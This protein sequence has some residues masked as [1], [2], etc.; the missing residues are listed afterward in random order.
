MYFFIDFPQ[1]SYYSQNVLYCQKCQILW[2]LI[3][4]TP[5]GNRPAMLLIIMLIISHLQG[6]LQY[7]GSDWDGCQVVLIR[8]LIIEWHIFKIIPQCSFI[9]HILMIFLSI[10]GLRIK[11]TLSFYCMVYIIMIKI[12]TIAYFY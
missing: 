8:I 2:N 12:K 6:F 1:M 7:I 9:L 5:H 10:K 3:I 4:R 11:H